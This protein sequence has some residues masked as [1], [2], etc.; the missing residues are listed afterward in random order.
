M[1]DSLKPF[2][3]ILIIILSLFTIVFFEME[4]RRVNYVILRKM[5][6]QK[7]LMDRTNK[8]LMTYLEKTRGSRL[9]EIARSQL[10]LDR[11]GEGQVILLLDGKVAV[12]Q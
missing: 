5:R 10:V 12:S 4:V 3:S 6:H 8:N 9:D 1:S 11:A 2:F 7:T